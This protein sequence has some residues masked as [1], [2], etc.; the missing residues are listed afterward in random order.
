M[1]YDALFW[2]EREDVAQPVDGREREVRP[3]AVECGRG[4]VMGILIVNRAAQY[5]ESD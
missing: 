2:Q 4:I 5:K 1:I 3:R